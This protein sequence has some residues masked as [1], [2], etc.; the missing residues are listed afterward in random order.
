MSAALGH[1]LIDLAIKGDRGAQY[2]MARCQTDIERLWLSRFVVHRPG[3]TL[4]EVQKQVGPYRVDFLLN[5]RVVVEID[6]YQF[7][8]RTR[9]ELVHE[10]ER[11][12]YL[13]M[14]GLTILRFTG[15]EV[16]ADPDRCAATVLEYLAAWPSVAG[17]ES[18][19]PLGDSVASTGRRGSA[20]R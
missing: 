18:P 3:G 13:I 6:G 19:A 1:V 2:L 20:A 15:G 17:T 12:R 9:D 11:D 10:Y 5:A 8:R 4:I 16:W 14:Q 7:H